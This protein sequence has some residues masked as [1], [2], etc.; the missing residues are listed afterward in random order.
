MTETF[1]KRLKFL[2]ERAGWSQQALAERV[3]AERGW[4]WF[5]TTIGKIERDARD[6]R[7]DEL[8]ALA[9]VFGITLDQLV[10]PVETYELHTSNDEYDAG[11]QPADEFYRR[12]DEPFRVR[13]RVIRH[14]QQ[15]LRERLE[16][17]ANEEAEAF[18]RL[19]A[20]SQAEDDPEYGLI[21]ESG[22]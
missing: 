6:V 13:L 11:H 7:V 3:N 1:G 10:Q 2:R 22:R 16:R 12:L 17:L 20:W 9:D 14:E 8:A 5:Q 15:I 19:S 4:R 21:D 18:H